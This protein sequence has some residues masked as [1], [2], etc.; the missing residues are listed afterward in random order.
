M[1]ATYW[2]FPRLTGRALILRQVAIAQPYLWFV[3]MMLFA[4]TN[5]ITGI[6]GQPR[7]VYSSHFLG[8]QQ[9]QTWKTLT[10]ISAAGGIVLFVSSLCFLAVLIASWVKGERIEPPPFTFA[11]AL[12]QA[13]PVDTVWERIGLWAAV[14]VVL[15]LAAYAY[16]IWHLISMERYGSPP[17]TPF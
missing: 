6:M 11:T 1:G 14:A 17:F 2:L 13:E 5:H 10:M 9:A 16:P 4:V 12:D 3:G 7:R 15:V 8:D